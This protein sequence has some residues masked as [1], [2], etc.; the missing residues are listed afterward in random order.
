ME[1]QQEQRVNKV[2]VDQN[3]KALRAVLLC[4][5]MVVEDRKLYKPFRESF[6]KSAMYQHDIDER[7]VWWQGPQA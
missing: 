2:I 6:A 3:T 4:W 1:A 5:R 7:C